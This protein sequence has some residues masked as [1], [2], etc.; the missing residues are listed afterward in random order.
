MRG[1]S[2][3]T[4]MELDC[5]IYCFRCKKKEISLTS[6]QGD[7]IKRNTGMM[8]TF[9]YIENVNSEVYQETFNIAKFIFCFLGCDVSSVKRKVLSNSDTSISLP[10]RSPVK[11]ATPSK[12]TTFDQPVKKRGA[13]STTEEFK[14][15]PG[16]LKRT[17]SVQKRKNTPQNITGMFANTIR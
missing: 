4:I 16:A 17:G 6:N 13:S 3:L 12:T 7:E 9:I 5:A 15:P 14:S 2:M 11:Q 10:A 8:L 1:I